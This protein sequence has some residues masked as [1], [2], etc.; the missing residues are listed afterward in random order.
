[1]QVEEE[2]KLPIDWN[3]ELSRMLFHSDFHD[4]ACNNNLDVRVLRE[5]F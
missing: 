3:V 5:S 1:L 4:V 2:I